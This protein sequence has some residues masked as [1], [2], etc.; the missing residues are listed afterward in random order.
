MQLMS[1]PWLAAVMVYIALI[2][3]SLPYGPV[4]VRWL[5]AGIGQGGFALAVNGVLAVAALLLSGWA[6][7]RLDGRH[8]L[9]LLVP[10]AV[11][12]MV[13][14]W[15]DNPAERFHF[16]LYAGLG[17]LMLMVWGHS[18]SSWAVPLSM[19]LAALVGGL[20]ELV[21]HF[22][23]MRV[24]DWRDVA[25]NAAGGTLGVWAAALLGQKRGPV[26]DGNER[27]RPLRK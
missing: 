13:T 6:V 10:L 24:G 17:I 4:V 19:V 14:I 8:L 23:P 12:G 2:L 27:Q 5:R 20:D 26:D 11:V 18:P 3:G 21:Q 22:L 1:K 15:M 25:M 9:L 16:L 7:R